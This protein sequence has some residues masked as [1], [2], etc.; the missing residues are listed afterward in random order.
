MR[1]SPLTVGHVAKARYTLVGLRRK[2]QR[3]RNDEVIYRR[4]DKR[5]TFQSE[6]RY[7]Q[8]DVQYP[9]AS[10]SLNLEMTC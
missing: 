6:Q 7:K 2:R 10:E 3:R 1:T 9:I 5:I 4:H 8:T